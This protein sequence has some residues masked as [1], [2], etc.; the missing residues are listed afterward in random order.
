MVHMN[1]QMCFYYLPAFATAFAARPWRTPFA[2]LSRGFRAW[3][4]CFRGGFPTWTRILNPFM[5]VFDAA[6]LHQERIKVCNPQPENVLWEIV[7]G[8]LEMPRAPQKSRWAAARTIQLAQKLETN[9]KTYKDRMLTIV[10]Q[11]KGI[12]ATYGEIRENMKGSENHYR[13]ESGWILFCGISQGDKLCWGYWRCPALLKKQLPERPNSPRG[14]AKTQKPLKP[15]ACPFPLI[16]TV[17][18]RQDMKGIWEK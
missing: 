10:G 11:M 1:I 6:Q 9:S 13:K 14:W 17:F 5:D 16:P 4:F 12:W 2:E 18:F 8:V 7:L 3:R 15:N